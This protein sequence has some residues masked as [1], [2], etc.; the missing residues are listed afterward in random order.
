[1]LYL[2]GVGLCPP[3]T[4]TKRGLELC[5]SHKVFVETHTNSFPQNALDYFRNNLGATFVNRK[6]VEQDIYNY[7]DSDIVLLVSGDPLAATTHI[8]LLEYCKK[9]QIPYEIVDNSSI[10]L[11]AFTH[12][13][14]SPYKAGRVVTIPKFGVTDSICDFIHTNLSNGLHTLVLTDIGLSCMNVYDLFRK[15]NCNLDDMYVVVLS[16]VGCSDEVVR[17]VRFSDISTMNLKP[18]ISIIIPG[19][20]NVVENEFLELLK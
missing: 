7:L 15:S 8:S 19:T 18:P 17:Y 6:F 3:K 20:L 10:L 12:A 1:M 13:G 11:A 14:L 9:N 2:V 5:K 4:M 16:R